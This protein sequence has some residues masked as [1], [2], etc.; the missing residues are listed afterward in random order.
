MQYLWMSRGSVRWLVLMSVFAMSACTRN[1]DAGRPATSHDLEG[2]TYS[3]STIS[4]HGTRYDHLE[5]PPTIIFGHNGEFLA[6]TGCNALSGSYTLRNG[7]LS[8]SAGS[9]LVG[10]AGMSKVQ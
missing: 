1:D 9:T 5:G 3:V 6:D 8:V 2:R 7:Q 4:D 10:C